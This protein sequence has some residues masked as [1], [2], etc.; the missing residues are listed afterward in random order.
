MNLLLTG[1]PGVGKTTVMSALATMLEQ[2]GITAVG[3]LAVEER[4]N[5]RRVGFRLQPFGGHDS[6]RMAHVDLISSVRIGRYGIDVE[7]ISY[8]VD[9]TLRRDAPLVLI[10][11]IGAMECASKRFVDRVQALLDAPGTVV[12]TIA[13]RP[14][15]FI[16]ACKQRDDV[17][18]LEVDAENRNSLPTELARR[19]SR[20]R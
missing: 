17:E 13:S 19:I 5:G 6:K 20:G 18:L 14:G 2:Q 7:I 9:M 8:M 12:A 4:V 11:E 10:D 15:D 1:P 16:D 3:F